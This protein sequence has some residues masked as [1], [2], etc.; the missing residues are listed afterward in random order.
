MVVARQGGDVREASHASGP[1]G[2]RGGG[3][4]IMPGTLAQLRWRFTKIVQLACVFDLAPPAGFEPA[5]TAP[6]CNP[7]YSRYQQEHCLGFMRGARMGRAESSSSASLSAA[8]DSR[9]PE[10]HTSL[11]IIPA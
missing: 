8:I 5:H 1:W 11:T 3:V 9:A 2:V 6:E 10:G 4:R 7:A